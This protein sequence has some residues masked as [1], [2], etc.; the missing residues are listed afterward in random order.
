VN[1][2]LAFGLSG[3]SNAVQLLVEARDSAGS[4]AKGADR[5]LLIE[6]LSGWHANVKALKVMGRAFGTV[7]GRQERKIKRCCVTAWSLVANG[8][9][10]R[11]RNGELVSGRVA[12]SALKVALLSWAST[13]LKAKRT[14][15]V[16][17]RFFGK[18][19][20]QNL[21]VA[22]EAFAS[23]GREGREKRLQQSIQDKAELQVMSILEPSSQM[24]LKY[25]EQNAC[26]HACSCLCITWILAH[27]DK[28][29]AHR[30][31]VSCSRQASRSG[32]QKSTRSFASRRATPLLSVW[33]IACAPRLLPGRLRRGWRG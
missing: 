24:W 28:D 32:Q 8:E 29:L 13:A 10:R 19:L 15:G 18:Q 5:R 20:H 30:L 16:L 4:M 22:F 26:M 14:R 11:A 7:S 23:V 21:V 2:S 31:P 1:Q 27:L 25:G 17:R 33:L 6:S 9:R 3:W 12:T